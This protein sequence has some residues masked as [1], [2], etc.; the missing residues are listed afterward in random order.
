MLVYYMRATSTWWRHE[1]GGSAWRQAARIEGNG[2][3]IHDQPRN[4][5]QTLSRQT[6]SDSPG[7]G[8]ESHYSKS[9]TMHEPRTS[10]AWKQAVIN[11]TNTLTPAQQLEFKGPA[12]VNDCLRI[13]REHQAQKSAFTRVLRFFEPLIDTLKRFEG[14]IDVTVQVNTGIGSPIWGRC[15]LQSRC[16][17]SLGQETL[18]GIANCIEDLGC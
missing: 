5:H 1:G 16:A 11:H 7:L 18:W 8:D 14:A 15:G 4:F 3:D 17:R 13:L 2:S 10:D 9:W 6:M 12:T